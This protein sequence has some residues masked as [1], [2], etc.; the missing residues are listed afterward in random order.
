VV[1]S[2]V[3][4]RSAT[5]HLRRANGGSLPSS[6]LSR[7]DSHWH[8][9]PATFATQN[10]LH[11]SN[12]PHAHEEG[13]LHLQTIAL[14]VVVRHKCGTTLSQTRHAGLAP[15]LVP[16]YCPGYDACI[17]HPIN[18]HALPSSCA[19]CSFAAKCLAH[20]FYWRVAFLLIACP[21]RPPPHT[22]QTAPTDT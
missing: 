13:T 22:H 12:T 10:P 21:T 8:K 3:N 5:L 6:C 7:N 18:S 1:A 17:S 14:S 2:L 4:Q 9:K 15:L 11:P 20:R 19:S 16:S